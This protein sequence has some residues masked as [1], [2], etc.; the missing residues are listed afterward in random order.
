MTTSL[1]APF[2]YRTF[3]LRVT[4]TRPDPQVEIVR[5]SGIETVQD[6]SQAITALQQF[7]KDPI[8]LPDVPTGGMR[9]FS[10]RFGL[11]ATEGGID[12]ELAPDHLLSIQ[13][14]VATFDGC[15][16]DNAEV[17]KVL[18]RRALFSTLTHR[19]QVQSQLIWP[20]ARNEIV[21]SYGLSGPFTVDQLTVW[22][23]Q[24]ERLRQETI[25]ARPEHPGC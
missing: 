17:T 15:G 5:E 12:L 21:G 23:E 11:E 6:L 8:V 20:V 4:G 24:M 7:I 25:R 22:A 10:L 3:L 9:R 19:K 14:G 1:H 16:G 18:G 13:Y 2:R